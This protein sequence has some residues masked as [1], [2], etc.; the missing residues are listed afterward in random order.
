VVVNE[1]PT[2]NLM[3]VKN[4][5]SQMRDGRVGDRL[6]GSPRYS[7]NAVTVTVQ[8]SPFSDPV[9][10]SPHGGELWNLES[11]FWRVSAFGLWCVGGVYYCRTYYKTVC[12]GRRGTVKDV[13]Y[14]VRRA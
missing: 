10:P 7:Y 4:D 1:R 14:E 8:E 2:E 11:G 5:V 9:C 6:R 13:C 12:G 3:A